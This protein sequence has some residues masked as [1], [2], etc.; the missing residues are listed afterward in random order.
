[1][2]TVPPATNQPPSGPVEASSSVPASDLASARSSP[3]PSQAA[4]FVAVYR[5]L[6]RSVATPGRLAAI[7]ALA[8]VSILTALA[9]NASSPFDPLD[10]ATGYVNGN[11]STLVPVAVLVFGAATLGDLVD[12][13]TLVYLWLR[14]VPARVHVLAAWAATVTIAVPLVGAPLVLATAMIEA[15]G[16]LIG[17][18]VLGLLV[19]ISAYSAL[20]VM[21]GIRFRRALPWGLVYILIWEGFVASAGETAARLAVRS[22]VRSILAQMTDQ[23]IKLAEFNLASGILVPLGVTAATLAYASRRLAHTDVA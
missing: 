17:A 15:D 7:G 1:M 11:L 13:G 18:T 3:A 21:A 23:S 8:V 2:T 20:F 16:P 6:L 12:D 10:A 5:L 14:P 4:V 19:G 9:V 22:Y